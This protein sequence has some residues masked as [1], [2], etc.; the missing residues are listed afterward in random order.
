MNYPAQSDIWKLKMASANS[1]NGKHITQIGKSRIL[2]RVRQVFPMILFPSELIVE[3]L[4]IVCLKQLGP[5]TN[6]ILSI[7]ATDIASVNSSNGLFFGNIHIKS[8]TGGPEI[9]VDSLRRKDVLKVRSLVE[10]IA[11]S[12]REG[13]TVQS[14]NLETEKQ[15]LYQAGQV[16]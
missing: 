12:A 10:G 1:I 9:T 4:R 2:F 5:W 8:L 6:E 3:E 13:L 7:M 16:N 11:L 14:K 15:S